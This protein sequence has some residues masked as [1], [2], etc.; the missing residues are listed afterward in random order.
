MP[1]R[2]DSEN[3]KFDDYASHQLDQEQEGF[4]KTIKGLGS[5]SIT[6]ILAFVHP[7]C[8]IGCRGRYLVSQWKMWKPYYL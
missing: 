2:P 3:R 6:E 8:N 4:R 5:A 7:I 1:W